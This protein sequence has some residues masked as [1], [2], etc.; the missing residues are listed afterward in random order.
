VTVLVSNC[1]SHYGQ[2]RRTRL[3]PT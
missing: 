1:V 2:I 3:L